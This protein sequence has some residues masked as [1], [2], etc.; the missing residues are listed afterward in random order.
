MGSRFL[1]EFSGQFGAT[2]A[3]KIDGVF[4]ITGSQESPRSRLM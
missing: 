2:H 1:L 3:V 4:C